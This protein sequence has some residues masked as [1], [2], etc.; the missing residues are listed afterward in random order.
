MCV[1][2]M[3]AGT[4]G[5]LE[6]SVRAEFVEVLIVSFCCYEEGEVIHK[7]EF[8]FQIVHLL[9]RNTT[10][11]GVVGI[12][13]V[14]IIKKFRSKHNA[15]NKDTMDVEGVHDKCRISLNDTVDIHKGKDKTLITAVRIFGNTNEIV[16]NGDRR[17]FEG[18]EFADITLIERCLRSEREWS[19]HT[20]S[21]K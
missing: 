17:C 20:C 18:M 8:Y 9:A 16:F 7:E 10:H 14:L 12:I 15:R 19:I 6:L 5:I 13:V 21:I 3:C 2:S 4:K 11:L 1:F